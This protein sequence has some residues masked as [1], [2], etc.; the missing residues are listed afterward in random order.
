MRTASFTLLAVG[1]LAAVLRQLDRLEDYS[2][3]E[4]TRRESQLVASVGVT[5]RLLDNARVLAASATPE[6]VV[7]AL[8]AA[9]AAVADVPRV[10]L[11]GVED[12]GRLAILGGRGYDADSWG[13]V[14]Q[15]T[16]QGLPA[17]DVAGSGQPVYVSGHDPLLAH[18]PAL[19][20]VGVHRTS[21][22][23]LAAVPMRVGDR[24]AGVLAVTGDRRQPWSAAERELLAGLAAQGGQALERARLYERE[25]SAVEQLQHALL[26]RQLPTRADVELAARY[27]PGVQGVSVGGDWYDCVE[28]DEQV[29]LVVGDVIGMGLEAAA[30]MGQ[31]R[32]ATRALASID[33]SPVAVLRG[34]DDLIAGLDDDA[35]FATVVY[36]LLDPNTG[37]AQIARAGHVP[38]V[39][40]APGT[41]AAFSTAGGSLPLGAPVGPRTSATVAMPPGSTMVL[42][43]DGLV[44]RHPDGVAAGLEGVRA[45]LDPAASSAGADV[46]AAAVP[47]QAPEPRPDDIAVLVARLVAC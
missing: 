14:Q 1:A 6:Q 4:L 21:T 32:T 31:L 13:A 37:S 27:L 43:S 23:R 3:D 36:V 8:T 7:D 24:V 25:R 10:L 15:L 30:L 5:E 2:D 33:P 11:F 38:P 9:A 46:I 47:G 39:L 18:Y 34:L 17:N 40:V 29:A 35:V 28:C 16:L 42:Y 41:P 19:A 20:A 26:P 12:D 45:R 22:A 44:E